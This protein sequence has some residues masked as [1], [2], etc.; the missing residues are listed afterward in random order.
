MADPREKFPWMGFIILAIIL[1]AAAGGGYY[2][3]TQT[4]LKPKPAPNPLIVKE[5]DNVTV[6]YVGIFG[7]G[8]D[9]GKVFDTSLLSVARDNSTWPKALSFSFR[10]ASG[11]TPLKAH[12]GPQS[13]G[14]YTSLISGFWTAMVGLTGNQ[15][16]T[17]VIPPKQGYGLPD[18]SKIQS[19][20]LTQSVP[21]LHFYTPSEFSSTYSGV[22]VQPGVFTDPHWG[23]NDTVLSV[24][25]TTVVVEYT[26]TVGEQIHPL[27]WTDTVT[28]V[29]NTIGPL[30]TISYVNDLTPQDVGQVQGTDWQ[31]SNQQYYLTGVSTDAGTYTLDFNSEVTGQTLIFEITVVDILPP[32]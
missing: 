31:S 19:F 12:V 13:F 7:S 20:P 22:A 11:Y 18:L 2:A 29:S 23:W 24:N 30:G 25:A 1:V 15:T 16:I 17:T 21:M 3:L 4:V 8:I 6:N 32:H 9:Q 28:A 10:G 26:P 14:S 5:G 27:G